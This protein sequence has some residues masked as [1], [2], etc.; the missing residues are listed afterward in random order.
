MS[1]RAC[2]PLVF[3]RVCSTQRVQSQRREKNSRPSHL[4]FFPSIFPSRLRPFFS[5]PSHSKATSTSPPPH[6]L[7]LLFF[8]S[9]TTRV[10]SNTI[11]M[12]EEVS[13][14]PLCFLSPHLEYMRACALQAAKPEF[15]P[16]LCADFFGHKNSTPQ[17]DLCPTASQRSELLGFRANS[18]KAAT[19]DARKK[20]KKRDFYE[21]K[22]GVRHVA[23]L[24]I[25]CSMMLPSSRPMPVPRSPTP[26]SALL[27]ARTVSL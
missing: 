18:R 4:F 19:R 13:H 21:F 8:P 24:N 20:K 9:Q 5:S 23:N 3:R 12:S 11:T 7:P 17:C 22:F 14:Q 6:S 16:L 26:C 1:A 27:C 10:L 2:L 15:S 25:L